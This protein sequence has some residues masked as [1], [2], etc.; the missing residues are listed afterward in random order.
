[1]RSCEKNPNAPIFVATRFLYNSVCYTKVTVV[2]GTP[3]L[4]FC[5]SL[6]WP[7]VDGE[8]AIPWFW[9]S[10]GEKWLAVLCGEEQ[11]WPSERPRGLLR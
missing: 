2:L 11:W 4:Q 3:K 8:A 9:V 6:F 5:L 10:K 7:N 1:M